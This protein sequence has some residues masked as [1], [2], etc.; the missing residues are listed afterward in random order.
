MKGKRVYFLANFAVIQDSKMSTF[1]R[2]LAMS[3]RLRNLAAVT[4]SWPRTV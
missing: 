3:I 2:R 4:V 1:L